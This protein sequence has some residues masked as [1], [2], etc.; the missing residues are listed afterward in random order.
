LPG[1]LSARTIYVVL[2]NRSPFVNV[3]INAGI[4]AAVLLGL[5]A[6]AR[7]Q[8][9][10]APPAAAAPA[11]AA[12][13]AAAYSAMQLEQMLAPIALYPDQLLGP[14]LMASTYPLE[15]VQ[16]DRW[17]QNDANASLHGAQLTEA[18][19]QESWDP[20][21]KALVPFPQVLSLLDNDLDWTEQVGNAFLA[22]QANVMDAVQR[23][24][25][26]AQAAGTLKSSPQQAVST[27]GQDIDIAPAEPDVV[28]VPVYNPLSAYG[29]WPWADYPPDDF[30]VT[31]YP[32]GS[33]I[34]VTIV[35]SLWG[36]NQWDWGH[37]RLNI[38]SRPGPERPPVHPAAWQHNPAHRSGVPYVD[39]QTRTRFE[40]ANDSHAISSNFRGYAPVQ[41]A[42]AVPQSVRSPIATPSAPAVRTVEASPNESAPV[43]RPRAPAYVERSAVSTFVSRPAPPAFE[44]FGR[45]PQVYMQEQRGVSSRMSVPSGGGGGG[46][47]RGEVRR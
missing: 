16:A 38:V 12:P 20:S 32:F 18:L 19:Q 44:S 40:G 3:L 26:R 9:P 23:L 35:P 36:W 42:S 43:E 4:V 13:S 31:G 11:P 34:G 8:T 39:P 21:V 24:R 33:F 6:Q 1:V 27:E 15:I 5:Q 17:L 10:P 45:G 7:S 41:G 30:I 47:S 2:G 22:Q 29:G 46:G 25:A 37:H 28:Y 14:I